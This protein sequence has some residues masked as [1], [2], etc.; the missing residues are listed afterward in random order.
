MSVVV[1]GLL[2]M[3]SG[4]ALALW[5]NV[6]GYSIM[7]DLNRRQE[8]DRKITFTRFQFELFEIVALHRAFFPNSFKPRRMFG[9][10]VGGVVLFLVGFV[11]VTL[12]MKAPAQL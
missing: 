5:G 9:F 8:V 4:G 6:V 1:A 10:G 7:E 3:V 12:G 2:L 11:L